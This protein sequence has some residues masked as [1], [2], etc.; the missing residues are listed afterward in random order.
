MS[1]IT[2]VKLNSTQLQ[3]I[4]GTLLGDG[5]LLISRNLRS[6]RLQIRHS[7]KHQEYVMWKYQILKNLVKTKARIDKHNNSFYFRTRYKYCLKQ[8]Y[9]LFYPLGKKLIPN[10]IGD[11]LISPLALATWLMDDGNGYKNYSGFRIST[12][13]FN[14]SDNQRLQQCLDR[15]FDLKTSL[16]TDKKGH[17]ILILSQSSNRLK[18][19]IQPYITSC[20]KYKFRHLTP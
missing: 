15:N 16:C 19:I 3:L 11:Y 2:R 10:D 5:C 6:A 20:M 14:L 13:G 18:N 8:L 17:Q 4:V 9:E 7:T 12:Y 1:K